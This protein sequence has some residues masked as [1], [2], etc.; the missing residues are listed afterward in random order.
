[1]RDHV[2]YDAVFD[3]GVPYRAFVKAQTWRTRVS[4]ANTL[5]LADADA[6]APKEG[7]SVFVERLKALLSD[8]DLD[9]EALAIEAFRFDS[10]LSLMEEG[11]A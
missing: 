6:P 2:R 4:A 11:N 8:N 9:A 3:T 1:L 7:G 10:A 5:I